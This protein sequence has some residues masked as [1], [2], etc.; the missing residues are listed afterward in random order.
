MGS[1]LELYASILIPCRILFW[2][3]AQGTYSSSISAF[4]VAQLSIEVDKELP[5]ELEVFR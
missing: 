4:A 3:R 5:R 1:N 2:I